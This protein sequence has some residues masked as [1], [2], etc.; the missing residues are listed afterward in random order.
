MILLFAGLLWAK[1]P[2]SKVPTRMPLD[3]VRGQELYR[4]FCWQCHGRRALGKGPLAASFETPPPPLAGRMGKKDF[5][6]LIK[7]IQEGKGTMPAYSEII[8]R[9]DSRRILIWLSGL[10]KEKGADLLEEMKKNF[11]ARKEE[12]KKEKS[13]E[14]LKSPD[15]KSE[16]SK[17]V[18]VPDGVNPVKKDKSN[19]P[20][21]PK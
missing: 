15:E 6:S 20:P 17:S 1:K 9:H 4:D 7:L 13:K 18:L 10:D 2:E 12:L 3:P 8:D 19:P 14:K 11:D 5:K 21:A 16:K